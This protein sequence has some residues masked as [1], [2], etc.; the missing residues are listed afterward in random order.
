MT[1]DT[2]VLR[3]D[4]GHIKSDDHFS[5]FQPCPFTDVI[6][7]VRCSSLFAMPFELTDGEE[8]SLMTFVMRVLN[9]SM[10]KKYGKGDEDGDSDQEKSDLGEVKTAIKKSISEIS[11][12]T[13]KMWN[14]GK[15]EKAAKKQKNEGGEGGK[16]G[17]GGGG[18]G[19]G[20]GEGGASSSKRRRIQT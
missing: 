1:F 9:R 15:Q 12:H 3:N 20:E 7:L 4:E 10:K 6:G 8:A 19:G 16:G 11:T 13:V 18:Q 14:L 5:I 2:H 17:K